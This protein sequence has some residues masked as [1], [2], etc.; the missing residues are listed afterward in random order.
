MAIYRDVLSFI[1]EVQIDP[2]NPK[3]F[4]VLTDKPY[5]QG[6]YAVGV[7]IYPEYVYDPKGLLK[8]FALK[9]L[10]DPA[11]AAALAEKEENLA[12]FAEELLD[13]KYSRDKEFVRGCGPYALEEWVAGQRIVLKKKKDW[14]GN[15]LM[16]K[17]PLL[18]GYPEEM[19]YKIVPNQNAG[20]TM[21]KEED[22]DIIASVPANN[23]LELKENELVKGKYNFFTPLT[24]GY[25]YIGINNN[26]PKL[27]QK[28]VRRALA[29]LLN[30]EEVN[31]VAYQGLAEK[32]AGPIL[33]TY[34]FYN[35]SLQYI[36]FNVDQAKSLLQ[37]AGWEDSDGN[38]IVDK[39]IDGEQVE[40]SLEYMISPGNTVSNNVALI[41]REGARK[42]GVNIE[43]VT[44]E[45]NQILDARNKGNFEL[46]TARSGSDPVYYDPYQLWHTESAGNFLG[47][48]NAE[49]DALIVKLRNMPEGEER[50]ELYRQFQ[51][52]VYEEQP[53]IFINV[54][55][56]R[57]LIHKKF[58]NGFATRL[59]PGHFEHY[60]HY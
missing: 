41:F 9:D 10:S 48:G 40:M 43:I 8:D 30:V 5:L 12:T 3:K 18:S 23:F 21:V 56:E 57:I 7:W 6:P 60:L 4:T 55:M 26:S 14:W 15:K 16:E 42:A 34:S 38:G 11:K 51:Q 54:P 13:Q 44:K 33:P 31:D 28:E 27:N 46:Y 32:L 52:I 2:E 47:F 50:D 59:S 53:A 36:G 1:R 45:F 37:A 29:H 39:N 20:I 17:Y 22:L 35:K 25:N 49:T 19:T 24:F 58:K